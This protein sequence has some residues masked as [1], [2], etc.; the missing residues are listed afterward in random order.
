MR[1]LTKGSDLVSI[2]PSEAGVT[3][4]RRWLAQVR[5]CSVTECSDGIRTLTFRGGE[6]TAVP[7]DSRIESLNQRGLIAH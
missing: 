2:R 1:F 4:D 6:K 5:A 7:C 3:S